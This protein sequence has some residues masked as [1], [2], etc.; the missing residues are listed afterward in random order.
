MNVASVGKPKGKNPQTGFVRIDV[1]NEE[2]RSR[3]IRLDFDVERLTCAI[4]ELYP[5]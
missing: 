3:F 2:V 4:F 1:N 5:N